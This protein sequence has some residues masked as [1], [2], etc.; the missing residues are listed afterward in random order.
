LI[1]LC[2]QLAPAPRS[3]EYFLRAFVGL[4]G[5]CEER[6]LDDTSMID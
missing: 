1:Y 2:L 5:A 6:R 3:L 4:D